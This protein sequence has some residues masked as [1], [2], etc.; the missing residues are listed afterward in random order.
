[1]D[2]H[3]NDFA[4]VAEYNTF[5]SGDYLRPNVSYI[6]EIGGVKYQKDA[7]DPAKEYLTFVVLEDSTF[8]L[9]RNSV[10][11]SL[12]D[13][14]TWTTL[15]ANTSTPT[16]ASG[17]TIMWK[18]TLTPSAWNGIGIFYSTGG[19]FNVKGNVMSLLYGDNFIGQTDLT[20]K[21]FAFLRLFNNATKLVDAS[22]LILP[23]T[24]LANDCYYAMFSGCTGLTTAPELPATTLAKEC[25]GG[26]FQSCKSLTTAPELPA[27]TLAESCYYTI[28]SGCRNLNYIKMLATDI[29]AANCLIGWVENV[30]ATGTFVKDASMSSLPSGDSG[31]PSG[32]TVQDA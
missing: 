21:D 14:S 27:T 10:D 23:A 5:M 32:W 29:T 3:L 24:T 25:Y 15:P 26:M 1:M 18:G 4:T 16:V 19:T 6:E 28:F 20:G 8:K 17:S 12:D 30:A 11:Y 9:T 2:L 22:N 13:G 7:P 31:I